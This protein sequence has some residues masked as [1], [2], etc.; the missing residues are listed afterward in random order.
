M[1]NRIICKGVTFWLLFM[2]NFLSAPVT[3]R[4]VRLSEQVSHQDQFFTED[5]FI[6]PHTLHSVTPMNQA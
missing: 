1:K 5:P 6:K 2:S 3:L 4:N